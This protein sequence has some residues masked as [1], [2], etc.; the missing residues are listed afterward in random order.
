MFGFGLF[1][2]AQSMS[3]KDAKEVTIEINGDSDAAIQTEAGSTLL[4]T[5]WFK[6]MAIFMVIVFFISLVFCCNF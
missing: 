2:Q 4:S 6:L 1:A 3:K 5:L